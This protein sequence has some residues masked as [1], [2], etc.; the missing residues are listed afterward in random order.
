V[1]ITPSNPTLLIG[2]GEFGRAVLARIMPSTDQAQAERFTDLVPADEAPPCAP[3]LSLA[4]SIDEDNGDDHRGDAADLL[5]VD[6]ADAEHAI[7]TAVFDRCRRLLDLPRFVEGRRPTDSRGPHLDLFVI[8]DLSAPGAGSLIPRLVESLGARLRREFRPILRSGLGALSICP[9]VLAPRGSDG[10]VPVLRALADLCRHPELDRRPQARIY[11]V[12]DQSGK[13]LLSRAELERSFAAFLYLVLASELRDESGVRGLV[14]RSSESRGG[15]FATFACATLEVDATALDRLAVFELSR[16]VLARYEPGLLPLSEVANEAK[17]LL[18]DRI[19]VENELWREG[20]DI[21]LENYLEPPAI[22]VPEIASSDAPEDIADRKLGA[23][24]EM[25]AEKSIATFREDVERFKM[26]RLAQRI[27]TNGTTVAARAEHDMLARLRKEIAASP[28]GPSRA[29][30][31][32]RYA[33]TR[34]RGLVE[35]TGREIAAPNLRRFPPSPVQARVAAVREA[36]AARP[37]QDRIRWFGVLAVILASPL[38]AGMV[39]SAARLAVGGIPRWASVMAGCVLALASFPY[40]L[41]RH[42]RRHAN[43]VR[44]ARDDL[45]QALQH[46][47]RSDVVDYFR[48][49]LEY[50]RLLWVHR[51]YRRQLERLESV[52]ALLEAAAVA[53]AD[54]ERRLVAE[55]HDLYERSGGRE[56]GI[57][58]RT[59]LDHELATAHYEHVRPGDPA[60]IA[61][62]YQATVIGDRD[63]LEAPWADGDAVIA[64]CKLELAAGAAASPFSDAGSPIT[65]RVRDALRA[66]LEQLALSLSPP[67]EVVEVA[68]EAAPATTSVLLVPAEAEL[69]VRQ[70]LSASDLGGRWVLRTG[71]GDRSRIHLLIERDEL[72]IEALACAREP[73]RGTA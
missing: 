30:E 1:E 68:A 37:R 65:P 25:Q 38:L 35:A 18:P 27:E 70:I 52:I 53:L 10:V 46:Y 24:W 34:A 12:E 49:R 48:R 40:M 51:I 3:L 60:A 9:I 20:D 50:T 2:L 4:V 72:G 61:A 31:F 29:L 13:Y 63:P 54:T 17:P 42:V 19:A 39:H 16:E 22:A 11:V 56:V 64:H 21:S 6:A 71:S 45:H 14:E 41:W 23:I 47:L 59:V 58:Y 15:P 66:Y 5:R 55:S 43:W 36:A 32:A 33:A 62:R 57:L 28:R 67:L 73:A 44:E 69:L 26:D 7:T 8:A